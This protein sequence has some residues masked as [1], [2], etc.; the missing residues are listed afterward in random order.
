MVM[1]KNVEGINVEDILMMRTTNMSTPIA[2]IMTTNTKN[3]ATVHI[4]IIVTIKRQSMIA[5]TNTSIKQ[6]YQ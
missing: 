4:T 5:S 1:V 3:I 2:M 6:S